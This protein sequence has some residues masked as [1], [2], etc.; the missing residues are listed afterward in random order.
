[1]EREGTE[2]NEEQ[3]KEVKK[4]I[5]KMDLQSIL[6]ANEANVFEHGRGYIIMDKLPSGDV[7]LKLAEPEFPNVVTRIGNIAVAADV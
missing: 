5:K 3:G 7:M 6:Y 1:M 4:F 2:E